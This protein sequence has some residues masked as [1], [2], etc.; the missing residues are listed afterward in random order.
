MTTLRI[1]GGHLVDP[2]AGVDAP[3]DLLIE[4]GRVT[5][6]AEPGAL[7]ALNHAE[8]IDATGCHVLPGLI[9]THAHLREPGQ[10]HKETVAGAGRQAAMGGITHLFSMPNTD[11]V[12]DSVAVCEHITTLAAR[13]GTVRV[14]PVGALTRNMENK[15]LSEMGELARS[16]VPALADAWTPIE[17]SQMFRRAL[18]YAKGVGLPVITVPQDLGL[19]ADGVMHEGAV[20]TRLGLPGIPAA[21]EEISVSRAI[22]LAELTGCPLHVAPITTAGS[23]RMVRNARNRGVTVSAGTA[24]HYLHLTDEA[25]EGY[26][27][28]CKVYPPL[29]PRADV[30]ALRAALADGTVSVLSSCH[31]PHADYE[32][33]VEFNQAPFGM[34]ALSTALS[35]TLALVKEGVLPLSDAVTRWT[36][37]PRQVFDLS[38]GTLAVGAVADFT[39]VDLAA[40]WQVTHDAVGG[41]THGTPWLHQTLSGRVIRT[42]LGGTTVYPHPTDASTYKGAA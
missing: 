26:P 10:E 5:Q 16:G 8:T 32:K 27:T 40:D 21:S 9:D 30:E 2:A 11:P 35:L 22:A 1:I 6:V 31:A 41:R 37:G 38:C 3:K 42:A 19:S 7:P 25:V 17:S 24:P 4:D 13:A 39:L 28:A 14:L 36:A 29:R 34:A 23:V 20:S 15:V 12:C 18:E 33:A